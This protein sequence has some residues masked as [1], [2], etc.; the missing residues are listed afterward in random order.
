MRNLQV[1]LWLGLAVSLGKAPLAARTIPDQ[2][3]STLAGVAG[4]TWTALVEN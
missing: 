2:V 4:N 1:I 3:D